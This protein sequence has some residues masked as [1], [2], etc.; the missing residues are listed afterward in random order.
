MERSGSDMPDDANGGKAVILKRFYHDGLAQASYL[1]GCPGVGRAIV[2]DANRDVDQYIEAAEAEGLQITDVTETHIHA[3][4]VSGSRELANRT[5]ATMHMSDEGDAD[6]KYQFQDDPNFRLVKNG[7]LIEVGAIKLE[8]LHSPGHTPEHIS[9]VLTDTVASSQPLGVF[10]GDFI[11]VGDVGRPDLLERAA[12]MLGTM[13]KG[14]RIL[15]QSLQSIANLPDHMIVWPAHGA[16]SAC[17]KSLGG[18]PQSTLGYERLVNWG[19]KVTSEEKFVDEVLSGQPEPPYYFKEMKRINKVGPPILGGRK[20]PAQLGS[21]EFLRL[22]KEEALIVDVRRK[23][24]SMQQPM[25]GVLAVPLGKDFTQWAGWMLPFD[26]PIHLIADS[27]AQADE[28][29][30]EL[31]MIGLDDT[32]AWFGPSAVTSYSAEFGSMTPVPQATFEEA[33]QAQKEGATILDVR[34]LTE[35]TDGHI[36]GAVHIQYGTLPNR[37]DEV[38]SGKLYVHCNS[39]GRSPVAISALRKAG[40]TDVVNIPGGWEEYA[41]STSQAASV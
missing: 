41:A 19:M 28:A 5:G 4:Y 33:L 26:T 37:L 38:P 17:G 13:E 25:N 8:V 27:K 6:W 14:A 3:D 7:D 32:V 34:G 2:I 40:F 20:D 16:G 9:F 1:L 15:H 39:G 29:A 18:V 22:L 36:E 24:T 23:E 30:M 35:W 31:T 10:S 21:G 12:N 11:F